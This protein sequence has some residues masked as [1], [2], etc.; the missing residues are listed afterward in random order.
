MEFSAFLQDI[1]VVIVLYK[2]KPAQSLAYTSVLKLAG[3]GIS[4]AIY[5]YDNSPE[6]AGEYI[7]SARV[8]Y[9]HD[10]FNG[11]VG[12]AYNEASILAATLQKKWMLLSDQDTLLTPAFVEKLYRTV[13]NHASGIAFAPKLRDVHGY[14]SPFR[15]QWGGGR[16][17][18]V[19]AP[20]LPL[21]QY[22]FANSGLL[23]RLDA[24]QQVQGYHASLPLD[25][26]DIAFGEKLKALTRDF[27]VV[28]EALQHAFSG[29]DQ[30]SWPSAI[31]RFRYFC[32][33]AFEMGRL[34]GPYYLYM[35]RALLRALHLS[36]RYKKT[37][38]IKIFLRY[39]TNT[40]A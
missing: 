19:T 18:M 24:F 25:F 26:S 32:A 16:R 1:V 13:C 27:V 6:P 14:V 20:V 30:L 29:T 5:I 22:R 40:V 33:G 9:R 3:G 4:P 17:C 7:N 10:P 37:A 21:Q 35:G 39:S 38:F 36:A 31:K 11:G 8:V 12:K 15:W 23:I 34:Y 28:D 2:R